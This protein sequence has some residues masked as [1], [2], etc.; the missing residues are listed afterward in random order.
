M[1][2]IVK[3]LK[4]NYVNFP[5]PQQQGFHPNLSC[6]TTAFALQETVLYHIKRH[7][8]VYVVSFGQKAAFDTV[9]FRALFLKL[10]RQGFTRQFLRLLMSINNNLKV[11]V[12]ISG[13]T[14]DTSLVK[15]SVR[16][17]EVFLT[18][19]YLVYVNDLLNDLE[20]SGYGSKVMSICCGN[21][22]FADDISL[23]VLTPFHL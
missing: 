13:L 5:N 23:L 18:F 19:L 15:S 12:R 3:F 7:S 9:R 20:A 1:G 11:A 6:L 8:D 10:G 16:Q 2:R 14:S 17:V 22:A 21:P 4:T